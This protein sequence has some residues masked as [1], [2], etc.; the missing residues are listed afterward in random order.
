MNDKMLELIVYYNKYIDML[1]DDILLYER[2]H[3]NDKGHE[4]LYINEV[5]VIEKIDELEN[6]FEGIL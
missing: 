4:N 3:G 5:E 2:D 6:Y 1:M